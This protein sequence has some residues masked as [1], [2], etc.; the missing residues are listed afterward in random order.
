MGLASTSVLSRYSSKA[1][2]VHISTTVAALF[3]GFI[4][5]DEAAWFISIADICVAPIILKNT[6]T[7]LSSLRTFSYL[8]CGKPVVG[9][10][11]PGLG[12]MLEKEGIGASFTM[13]DH[14]ALA[15]TIIALLNNTDRLRDMGKKGRDFVVHNYSW[16]I[17]IDKLET[18]FDGLIGTI[19]R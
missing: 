7:G 16:E 15:K 17:I 18:L 12:D 2:S 8:A 5:W 19:K 3:F 1:A 13:G 14:K 10:N 9:S 11:I 4:P 6:W